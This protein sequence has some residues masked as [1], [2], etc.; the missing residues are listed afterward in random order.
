[1]IRRLLPRAS[2]PGSGSTAPNPS[3]ENPTRSRIS[4]SSRLISQ[5]TEDHLSFKTRRSI[6]PPWYV[7]PTTWFFHQ[8]CEI[9]ILHRIPFLGYPWSIF[10]MPPCQIYIYIYIYTHRITC[11]IK[12]NAVAHM[13]THA[14]THKQLVIK[15]IIQIL[16]HVCTYNIL[17]ICY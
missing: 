17:G 5:S 14:R 2:P 4:Q 10:E 16:M 13:Y 15:F 8:P 12:F 11:E 7:V 9:Y 1:M 3:L 6:A